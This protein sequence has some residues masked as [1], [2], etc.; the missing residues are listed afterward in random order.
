MTERKKATLSVEGTVETLTTNFFFVKY[1]GIEHMA[2][3]NM[4]PPVFTSVSLQ[5]GPE[6]RAH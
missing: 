6:K 4:M 3:A 2:M 1:L 5:E